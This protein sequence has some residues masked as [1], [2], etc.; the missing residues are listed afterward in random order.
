MFEKL[1]KAQRAVMEAICTMTQSTMPADHIKP[2]T[3]G[4]LAAKG[5]VNVIAGRVHTTCAFA[6]NMAHHPEL[7][8]VSDV[9]MDN[10]RDLLASGMRIAAVK[11]L[12]THT[13]MDLKDSVAWMNHNYPK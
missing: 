9:C 13:G 12:R 8:V 5:M 4:S 1:T 7:Y 6:W 3:L 2:A 11:A 10:I